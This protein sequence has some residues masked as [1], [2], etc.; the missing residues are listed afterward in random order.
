M[1]ITEA[2]SGT[3]TVSTT[4]WSLTTDTAGPDTQTDDGVY[5]C[6]LEMNALADGDAFELRVYEKVL[7]TSTQRVV[8]IATIQNAQLEP[9]YVTP[10]LIL[11]HGWD[12]TLLKV[13]GTDRAINWSIRK[14]A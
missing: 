7:S 5:Q 6:F 10:S 13:A 8:L 4:E 1:A 3:E 12:M 9:V 11:L 14:V 2:F